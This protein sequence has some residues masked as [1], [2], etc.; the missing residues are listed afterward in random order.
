MSSSSPAEDRLAVRPVL[1]RDAAVAIGRTVLGYATADFASLQLSHRAFGTSRV[2]RGRVHSASDGE[3]VTLAL[4]VAV[5]GHASVSLGINQLDDAS[6]REIVPYLE[7]L[8]KTQIGTVG[9]HGPPDRIGLRTYLPVHLW[10]D[11][12]VDAMTDRRTAPLGAIFEAARAAQVRSAVFV[13]ASATATCVMDTSGVIAYADETDTELTVTCW[14]PDG[15]GSGWGGAAA[16][17]WSVLDPAAVAAHAIEL[18]S[19]SVTV[20]ALEPGRR[21]AIL[22]PAAVAP[23]VQHMASAFDAFGTIALQG[24]PFSVPP[25]SSK[26][27]QRVFDSRLT[28]RSDPADPDGGYRPFFEDG[29]PTAAM[30]WVEGGVLRNLAF[31][32]RYGASMG[33]VPYAT[34]PVSVRL[35]GDASATATV[36]DMIA[37]CANGV[38]VNRL[39]N[40][41]LKDSVTGLMA[42]VTRDG[43]FLV[44]NGK[45]DRAIKNFWFLESPWF[46][47]NNVEMIGAA[48]RTALGYTPGADPWPL[49]PIIVPPMVVRDFNFTALADAV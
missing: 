29:M 15:N 19:R 35:E 18:A 34:I 21:T 2:T 13:G 46:I 7:R 9:V 37:A 31:D 49:P 43:C 40:V 26:V 3:V 22:G 1:T 36:D 20:Q 10:H 8:A 14:A 48:H 41:T 44:R 24:T 6:L 33:K 30:T 32:P 23:L 27:G 47:F 38:Y 17:D 11:A 16:R 42:G 28:M 4:D 25:H 12:S 5:R 45:I 39:S